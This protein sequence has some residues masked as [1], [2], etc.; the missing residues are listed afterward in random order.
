MPRIAE[1][2]EDAEQIAELLENG[3]DKLQAVKT[4]NKLDWQ[5]IKQQLQGNFIYAAAKIVRDKTDWVIPEN[6]RGL[7]FPVVKT[8]INE[9]FLKQRLLGHLFRT[10]RNRQLA[11]MPYPLLN[12]FLR[13]EQKIRQLEIV[14]AS[15]YL[16]AI[17][18]TIESELNPFNLRRF[19]A[20][21][22]LYSGNRLLLN[23][24]AVNT[25]L[26]AN[27]DEEFQRRFKAQIDSIITIEGKVGRAVIEFMEKLENYHEDVLLPLLFRPLDANLPL[28]RAIAKRTGE[29]EEMLE[30]N[31][32]QPLKQIIRRSANQEE[33]DYLLL[34]IRQLF[35]GI[36]AVFKD[37][38][39]LPAARG[40][41]AAELFFGR[42]LAY[43][44]FL[45]KRR[46]RI[47]TVQ[48]ETEWQQ[49]SIEA[50]QIA[51]DFQMLAENK[52]E[53]FRQL[54][55]EAD[56]IAAEMDQPASFFGKLMKTKEKQQTK[57]DEVRKK[58]REITGTVH[59]KLYHLSP[60]WQEQVVNLE[61]DTAFATD[62][63]FR[64][65]ALPAGDN[66]ITAL[67]TVLAVEERR[68]EFDLDRFLQQ[69]A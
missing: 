37:F 50:D 7:N 51:H 62:D 15:K 32:L 38:Q 30:E 27:S 12:T 20:E 48:D 58:I 3:L 60:E 42:L 54:Q 61:F 16:F 57:L 19:L 65:Y 23:G 2:L 69:F 68:A 55:S 41:T 52:A 35:G 9:V 34:G 14:R 28:E 17:A 47:F 36:I 1:T 22:T 45:D 18:P 44:A 11:E 49:N 59:D 5:R 66:G 13:D 56:Q 31:I 25:A 43:S 4:D 64:R 10:L 8:F 40:S 21:D 46:R 33:L 6:K 29:Y 24:T 26:L 53:E 39:T 63:G 67:P